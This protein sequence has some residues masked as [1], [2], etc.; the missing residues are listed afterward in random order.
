[1]ETY[2]KSEIVVKIKEFIKD[3]K[4]EEEIR[5]EVIRDD[6]FSILERDCKVLYY[7]LDDTIEGCHILKPVNG[8]M[9]Q[10]VFIN[11][12]KVV[13]EQVWT[14]A[15][16]LGHVWQVDRFVKDSDETCEEDIEVIVGRFAA[17]FLMPDRIF[18]EE[19][20][21]KLI[22]YEFQGETISQHM[23]VELVTYLMNF[24][25]TPYKSVIRRF[26]E[27]G[28]VKEEYENKYLECFEEN[29]Q[30]YQKLIKENQ[31]TRLEEVKE[32]YSISNLQKD[33]EILEKRGVLRDKYVKRV[34][35]LFHIN[36]SETIG[37]NLEFKV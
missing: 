10:F 15:H 2:M 3:K 35:E 8:E 23:M 4:Q 36:E 16:E 12:D 1:M 33:L 18:I 22:E 17:E 19:V 6:V 21:R 29:I 11:T 13:Q 31:Y 34:R 28:F 9:E 30:L 20:R 24:F 5:N 26:V 27:T 7:S 37:D 14:A 32:V 25:C